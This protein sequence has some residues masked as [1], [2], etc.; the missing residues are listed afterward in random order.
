MEL[1]GYCTISK[2]ATTGRG[3]NLE[4]FI[5]KDCRVMEFAADGGVLVINSEATSL[6]SFD[7]VDVYRKFEC[8]ACGDVLCSPELDLVGQMIYATKVTTR[9]GGYNLLLKNMIIQASLMK[10][11]LYDDFLFQKERYDNE[12]NAQTKDK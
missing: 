5:G 10:G 8:K 12:I 9:K 6:A 1:A 3:S 7:K 2:N 4:S 11:K